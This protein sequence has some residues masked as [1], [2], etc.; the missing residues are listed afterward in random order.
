MEVN[1]SSLLEIK[2]A[3]V[4]GT[5]VLTT[6]CTAARWILGELSEVFTSLKEFWRKIKKGPPRATSRPA[7]PHPRPHKKTASASQPS[8]IQ[9]RNEFSNACMSWTAM[10]SG[11]AEAATNL[12][13]CPFCGGRA[14][15][16]TS[17]WDYPRLQRRPLQKLLDPRITGNN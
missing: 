6:A 9:S 17:Q 16:H 1:M 8:R 10:L 4:E 5:L 7:L 12:L 11:C 3:L 13:P 15:Q 14:E 2:T